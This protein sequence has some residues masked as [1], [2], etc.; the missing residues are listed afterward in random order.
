MRSIIKNKEMFDNKKKT[1][2]NCCK[3]ENVPIKKA[4][5]NSGTLT[6]V[7]VWLVYS[8]FSFKSFHIV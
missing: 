4:V 7:Y 5:E 2:F 6:I 3:K 1:L 8:F